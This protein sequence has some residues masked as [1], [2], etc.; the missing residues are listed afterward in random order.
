M[1]AE[2]SLSG[3]VRF[4]DVDEAER[5]S[6]ID[7]K[8]TDDEELE[9]DSEV[10]VININLENFESPQFQDSRYVLTSPRSLEA[11]SKFGIKI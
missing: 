2:E 1:S 4:E 7:E 8:I 11:C 6:D 10:S 5:V 9:A 3:R